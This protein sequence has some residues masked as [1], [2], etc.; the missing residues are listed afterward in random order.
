MALVA[1]SRFARLIALRF[2]CTRNSGWH[3]LGVI[4]GG[5][6]RVSL[7]TLRTAART[8]FYRFICGLRAHAG[9][10]S[11]TRMVPLLRTLCLLRMPGLRHSL[12]AQDIFAVCTRAGGHTFA[13]RLHLA[14]LRA[15]LVARALA[16]LCAWCR[17]L[18]HSSFTHRARF[19]LR[20]FTLHKQTGQNKQTIDLQWT[21]GFSLWFL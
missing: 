17:A 10:T 1:L 7:R 19:L 5:A 18:A 4:G 8:H 16:H 20:A 11:R 12:H 21:R 9:C 2:A 14:R 15:P 3:S 13:R 6:L